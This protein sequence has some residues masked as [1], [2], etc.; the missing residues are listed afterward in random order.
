MLRLGF[1]KILVLGMN[2]AVCLFLGSDCIWGGP[3]DYVCCF[4]LSFFF[5][6]IM[7]DVQTLF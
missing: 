7:L 4:I 2:W 6:V 5:F 1:A 3:L